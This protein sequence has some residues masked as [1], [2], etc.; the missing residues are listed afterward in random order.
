[1]SDLEQEIADAMGA[2]DTDEATPELELEPDTLEA[3]T[4][5][6]PKLEEPELEE[7]DDTGSPSDEV[8]ELRFK[9]ADTAFKNY[10]RRI[11]EIWEDEAPNLIPFG[12]SPS[13][14]PGFIDP[15]DAGQLPEDTKRTIMQFVGIASEVQYQPDG[16]VAQCPRCGGEGKT[17]TGSNV[18][19]WKTRDCSHC[20]GYGFYPPPTVAG[21][22]GT[23]LELI[24]QEFGPRGEAIAEPDTDA[25]GE[26][27]IL[28][29]GR[30]NPN[31]GKMPQFKIQVDPWGVT[32]NLTAQDALA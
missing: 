1:M 25:W 30:E 10:S 23:S 22:N 24:E 4:L 17:N 13:A 12:L 14:P 11:T 2:D 28:P 15:R 27:R 8:W 29:D 19:K 18:P 26:P 6:E 3:D 20:K 5:E 31:Y 21:S 9:K 7:P 32:A 16:S